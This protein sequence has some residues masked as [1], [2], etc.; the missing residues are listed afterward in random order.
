ME[1]ETLP[2]QKVR[3]FALAVVVALGAAS[4]AAPPTPTLVPPTSTA[5][6]G[7]INININN[8]TTVPI[9]VAVNG[10]A[11]ATEPAGGVAQIATG[12]LPARPWTIEAR[13]PSGRVL[14]SLS[15]DTNALISDRQSIGDFEVL[16]CGELVISV[17]GPTSDAPHPSVASPEPCD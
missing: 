14:A 9:T 6:A 2:S 10:A 1:D 11:I 7:P 3:R 4:C 13:S 12:A 16:A 17:G 15:V 8:G 5:L